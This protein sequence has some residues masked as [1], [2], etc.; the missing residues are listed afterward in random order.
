MINYLF[1]NNCRKSKSHRLDAALLLIVLL[2]IL[3]YSIAFPYLIEILGPAARL[4]SSIYLLP[5]ALIWGLRGGLI[6]GAITVMANLALH[7]QTNHYFEGGVIGPMV[8]LIVVVMVGRL[9]DLSRGLSMELS[10]RNRM[11][12]RLQINET[13]YRLLFEMESHGLALIEKETMRI[14]E[15]NRAA[16]ELFEYSREE[17]L[18]KN[19]L[20]LSAEPEKSLASI[21]RE[22]Q[23]VPLRYLQKKDGTI[24]PAEI[25]SRHFEL[26]GRKVQLLAVRNISEQ[27]EAD[28]QQ[29]L[30]EKQHQQSQ[31]LEAIGTLS[32][33]IAH[34]FNNILGAILG[35][36][37]LLQV[38]ETNWSQK[39]A[40]Y[41]EQ[42]RNATHR[43]KD[44]INQILTFSRKSEISKRPVLVIPIVKEALQLLYASI[45]SRIEIR[46]HISAGKDTIIADATQIH[47][48]IVNL[49]TNAFH[50]I[51][52]E[53]GFID[54]TVANTFLDET[55]AEL[56]PEI[57]IGNYLRISVSDTGDGMG[58]GVLERIFQPYFTTKKEKGSGLGLSVVHG[59]VHSHNGCITV[60][61][62]PGKGSA[63]HVYFPLA[64][65]DAPIPRRM[66]DQV[67]GGTERIL[68][69]DDEPA[70]IQM[71]KD[72]LELKGYT[73]ETRTGSL[74][75]LELIKK[76]PRHFDLLVTDMT[77]PHMTGIELRKEIAHIAPNLPVIIITGFSENLDDEKAIRFGFKRL[78]MKPVSFLELT[79]AVREVLDESRPKGGR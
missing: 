62:E 49:C 34:D 59:I 28:K 54:V 23:Q 20:T 22:E 42:I 65:A 40:S 1:L 72:T 12:E 11:E 56:H 30:I 60:E 64:M 47:Q 32:R 7:Q 43:A 71:S 31:K 48:I 69:V 36:T 25:T 33:G 67:A 24:F 4:L 46:Q 27:L 51:S 61:S 18:N 37:D 29:R 77:M 9:S 19:P 5:A 10:E 13:K 58:M 44:L 57:E 74:E 14:I 55:F 79:R 76:K 8:A 73:V 78:I 68:L 15:V 66:A 21:K 70:L 16:T 17:L 41:L 38:L 35:Y 26:Q 53:K 75:A 2:L 45:P 63:F 52:S 39:S 50:A 6:T 3:L